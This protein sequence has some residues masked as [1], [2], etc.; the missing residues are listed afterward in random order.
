MMVLC[1]AWAVIHR[2][3]SDD[4]DNNDDVPA[5]QQCIY[6]CRM[7][8]FF[9]RMAAASQTQTATAPKNTNDNELSGANACNALKDP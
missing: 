1:I 7:S 6:T 8:Y 9:Y 5:M 2:Q 4:N 3:R